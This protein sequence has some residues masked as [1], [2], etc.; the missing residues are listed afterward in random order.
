MDHAVVVEP[1]AHAVVVEGVMA[2]EGERIRLLLDG[3][4]NCRQPEVPLL[5][6]RDPRRLGE[7]GNLALGQRSKAFLVDSLLRE[8]QALQTGQRLAALR[9]RRLRREGGLERAFGMDRR[10][11]CGSLAL[12]IDRVHRRRVAQDCLLFLLLE[13]DLLAVESHGEE[14]LA[15]AEPAVAVIDASDSGAPAGPL[16]EVVLVLP[17]LAEPEGEPRRAVSQV[18]V[19]DEVDL[20]GSIRRVL[21]GGVCLRSQHAPCHLAALRDLLG[22]VPNDVLR[23]GARLER[24]LEAG[25]LVQLA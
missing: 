19:E 14:A 11:R 17:P 2:R 13:D 8:A 18:F 4:V 24:G 16:H 25:G 3:G 21:R 5:G 6:L 10:R 20:L 9:G 15:H 7:R 12:V 23:L 22:Q 1:S